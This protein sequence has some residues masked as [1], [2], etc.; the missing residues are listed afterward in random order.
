MRNTHFERTK[1]K[2]RKAGLFSL[3]LRKLLLLLR[4]SLF[5]RWSFLLCSSHFQFTSD[6]CSLYD[7]CSPLM[8]K[9]DVENIF[10]SC[11]TKIQSKN[12]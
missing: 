5:L 11:H 6:P 7:Y 1:K 4:S 12:A 9:L 8:G 10:K 2:P 3:V